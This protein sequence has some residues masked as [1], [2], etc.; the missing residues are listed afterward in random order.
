MELYIKEALKEALISYEGTVVLVS[1]EAAFYE[2]WADR[3]IDIEE[4]V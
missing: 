4:I 1:T 2:E 3:I